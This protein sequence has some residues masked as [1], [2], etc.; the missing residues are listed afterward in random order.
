LQ[1]TKLTATVRIKCDQCNY[2]TKSVNSILKHKQ[3]HALERQ[4]ELL[5][6]EEANREAAA[7]NAAAEEEVPASL[8]QTQGELMFVA[9]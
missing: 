7:A 8:P 4:Q 6:E 1:K 9:V 5:Y 3:I 2:S